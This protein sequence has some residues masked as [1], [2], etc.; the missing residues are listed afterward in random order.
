MTGLNSVVDKFNQLDT[1][2]VFNQFKSTAAEIEIFFKGKDME[3]H[4]GQ[5]Q[6]PDG[7]PE[8]L[9]RKGLIRSWPPAGSKMSCWRPGT[10]L[11]RPRPS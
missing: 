9:F 6:G 11:R 10:P 3:A 1:Q 5:R 8:G 4:H 7:Q 2:A